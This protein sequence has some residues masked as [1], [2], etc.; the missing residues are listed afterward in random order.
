MR[1]SQQFFCC[2][3]DKALDLIGGKVLTSDKGQRYRG[4]AD[5]LAERLRSPTQRRIEHVDPKG[6]LEY[7]SKHRHFLHFPRVRFG[8][9]SP[10]SLRT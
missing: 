6:K 5:F 1:I 2:L 7:A 9:D 3:E 4:E 8:A 10:A